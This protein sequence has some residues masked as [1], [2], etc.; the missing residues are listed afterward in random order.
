M[1]EP[2]GPTLIHLL[3]PLIAALKG[4][5]LIKRMKIK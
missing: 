1:V 3:E 4:L 5:L 2:T